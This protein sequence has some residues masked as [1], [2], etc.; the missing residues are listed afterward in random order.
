MRDALLIA[1][2]LPACSSTVLPTSVPADAGGADVA[3][4]PD[5]GAS[6]DAVVDVPGTPT[7]VVVPQGDTPVA[8]TDAVGPPMPLAGRWRVVRYQLLRADGTPALL[9]DTPAPYTDPGTGA[10]AVVRTNGVLT[11]T[12]SRFA[13]S[14]CALAGD[15]V[16]SSGVTMGRDDISATGLA[17]PGLLDD[18]AG[19][20][21]LPGGQT[22]YSVRSLGPDALRVEFQPDAG[23][24][25]FERATTA[26]AL[27]RVNAV[28]GIERLRPAAQRAMAHP[29]A[30]LLWV[31]PGVRAPLETNGV[32]LQFTGNWAPYPL[33]LAEPP[34]AEARFALNGVTLAAAMIVVYDDVNDDRQ[35]GFAGGDALRGVSSLTLAWRAESA[36]PPEAGFARTAFVDV[37]PGYQLA[38]RTRDISTGGVTLIPFDN[39]RPISPD[40]QVSPTELD[41]LTLESAWR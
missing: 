30:A 13:L 18:R 6:G 2:L 40:A 32:A 16:Y 15:H 35:L 1:V 29:R 37:Q 17:V 28:G 4:G 9:T 33:A 20:F 41:P 7:D 38:W 21:D 27:A 26:P 24:V 19:R 10:T 25:E 22:S 14:L 8:P 3:A 23:Y 31:R 36:T 12:P 39:T 5:V 34:A 11:L